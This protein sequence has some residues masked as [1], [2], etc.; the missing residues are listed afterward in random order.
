M[1]KFLSVIIALCMCSSSIVFS[2]PLDEQEN[3]NETIHSEE[4]VDADVSA[5]VSGN[6]D[7]TA[8]SA[9]LDEQENDNETIHSEEPVDADVSAPVSGNED[10]YKIEL[11]SYSDESDFEID[12]NGVITLY[13]GTEENLVIPSV[14]NG[15]NVTSIGYGAFYMCQNLTSVTIPEGV[16]SIGDEAFYY[17]RNL[18][19]VTIPESVTNIGDEVFYNCES[20]TSITIPKGVTSIGDYAFRICRNLTSITIPEGVTSIGD[21]AF[22]E[23]HSLTSITIPESVTSIGDRAFSGCIGLTSITIP[24]GVTSIGDG[25]FRVC[26]SLTSIIIPESV[27]SI[28]GRAFYECSSLTDITIPESVT[29]IGEIAFY[30]CNSLTDITIPE[31]VTSIGD[32][33]FSSCSSLTSINVD[34]NSNYVSVGGI[35]FNK[36][37]TSILQYPA[38]LK[39]SNYTIPES[40]TNIGNTAFWD[41]ESLTSIAI[42]E[43]VTSI[44]RIAFEGCRSLTNVTIPES[45]TSIGERAFYGCRSLTD[46]TIPKGVTS[47]GHAAFDS[48][49]SLTS[50]CFEGNTPT[51][52]GHRVFF[53]CAED[54]KIY[55][56]EGA[57]GFTTPTWNGYPTEMIKKESIEITGVTGMGNVTYTGEPVIGYIGTPTSKYTG[58]YEITYN[59]RDSTIYGGTAAPTELGEYT[60]TI[61]IPEGQKYKGEISFDF[62]IVK[63]ETESGKLIVYNQD[64][65][66]TKE[67]TYYDDTIFV[68][69]NPQTAEPEIS[70]SAF[71]F[72]PPK[73]NQMALFVGETQ[74]SGAVVQAEDGS[75]TMSASTR[76]DCFVIGENVITAK[77]VNSDNKVKYQEDVTVIINKKNVILA[78]VTAENSLYDGNPKKGYTGEPKSSLYKGSYEISYAGR[79]N[80][81]YSG[82]DAP[83]KTGYYTVT[84]TIPESE[85]Y[86][87]SLSLNFSIQ[88]QITEF[89]GGLKVY[90]E[91]KQETK[92][93]V[94][95]DII[96]VMAKPQARIQTDSKIALSSIDF[97]EPAEKEMALFMG[98]KQISGSVIPEN[99]I[100]TME[101]DSRE[102]CFTIGK[103]SI[104]AKYIGDEFMSDCEETVVITINRKDLIIAGISA[105]NAVYDGTAKKGYTGKPITDL[106]TGEYKVIYTGKN[107]MDYNSADAPIKAGDYTVTFTIPDGEKYYGLTSLDF[108]IIAGENPKKNN[109]ELNFSMIEEENPEK[110][111]TESSKYEDSSEIIIGDVDADNNLTINDAVCVLQK[112]LDSSS[113]LPVEE[114]ADNY[115]MYADVDDN[116]ILT[117]SDASAIT[118]KVLNSNF[119]FLA[120]K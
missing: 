110:N 86:S 10:E 81:E 39:E 68:K 35:L 40:V 116:G 28:G 105:E 42:S 1:K 67:F 61:K 83:T 32:G 52:F 56:Y 77:Y 80:T 21:E 49:S 25:T 95:G 9:P 66:Q 11:L 23:C 98:E 69:A 19:S 2:A 34:N 104:T 88:K 6:E 7:E 115:M 54:F 96:I 78:G 89:D 84:F 27:T 71:S 5:P 109:T 51:D 17:C 43:S 106:Y 82:T 91:D 8:L 112:V 107:G 108:S 38:G 103:N 36:D 92:E 62:N 72:A 76:L 24:E 55:Y 16:T 114:K 117:A 37:L 44:G 53:Y 87:G 113:K 118:Q 41:C 30:D 46:I 63:S 48:C 26:R 75:Y 18:T 20:L 120:E 3:D 60:V 119:V 102:N 73:A 58:E 65:A 79:N 97:A 90:N 101:V 4:P 50:S 94:Y 99:G 45:V 12:E 14:I 100:Y 15:T 57:E 33:A 64:N 74:I 93:F 29:S 31:S 85:K 111:N 70:L 47:I 22:Y 59:G 13:K